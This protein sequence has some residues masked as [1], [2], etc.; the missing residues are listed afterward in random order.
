[1]EVPLLTCHRMVAVCICAKAAQL[2]LDSLAVPHLSGLGIE[3]LDDA[4]L[5]GEVAAFPATDTIG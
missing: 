3:T 1:M 5:L 4:T 2:V